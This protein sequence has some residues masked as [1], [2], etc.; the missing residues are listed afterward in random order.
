[1]GMREQMHEA[2][3]RAEETKETCNEELLALEEEIKREREHAKSVEGLL[4]D[5]KKNSQEMAKRIDEI[6][7]QKNE[8]LVIREGQIESIRVQTQDEILLVHR[9]AEQKAKTVQSKLGRELFVTQQ[10]IESKQKQSEGS[11]S[12]EITKKKQIHAEAESNVQVL[13]KDIAKKLRG[14]ADKVVEMAEDCEARMIEVQRREFEKED[15]LKEKIDVMLDCF[16]RA[17]EETKKAEELEKHH[18]CRIRDT[19]NVL[20]AHFPPSTQYSP[21]LDRKMKTAL[22]LISGSD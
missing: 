20:G 6:E 8:Q 17:N 15:F 3:E 9:R 11:V 4:W 12:V 10:Q 1:M 7:A 16:Q 14:T 21:L 2:N 5:E 19:V 22:H 18:G 13:N